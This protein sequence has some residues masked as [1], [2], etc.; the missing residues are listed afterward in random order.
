MYRG[1]I[2]DPVHF[3]LAHTKTRNDYEE[4][5]ILSDDLLTALHTFDEYDL[6]FDLSN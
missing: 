3:A 6:C 2:F 1:R 5:V 4:W